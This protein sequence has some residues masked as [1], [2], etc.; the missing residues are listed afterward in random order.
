MATTREIPTPWAAERHFRDLLDREG[1]AHPD[2]VEYD[3]ETEELRFLWREPKVAI[4]IEL[5][6]GEPV[7]L[8]D[9]E[10]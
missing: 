5:S 10:W 2:R 7:D 9:G 1:F 8:R 4:V 3:P 6:D